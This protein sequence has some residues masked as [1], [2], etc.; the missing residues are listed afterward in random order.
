VPDAYMCKRGWTVLRSWACDVVGDLEV[1][2]DT[3]TGA[4]SQ[5]PTRPT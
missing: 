3:I 2:I 4:V 1:V 5:H